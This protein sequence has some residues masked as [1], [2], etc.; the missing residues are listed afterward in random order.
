M[1]GTIRFSVAVDLIGSLPARFFSSRRALILTALLAV[2][3]GRAHAQS[4]DASQAG[5]P[6]TITASWHFQTGDN[7]QWAA[8]AFDDSQWPLLRMDKSWNVQGYGGYSGYAWYRIQ[9]R[10]PPGREPLAL[11][12][13]R[14]GNSAEVY[15]DGQLIGEM[16]RMRPK[17][18]WL[19]RLPRNITSIRLPPALNGKTITL[20]IRAW[21]STRSAP[22]FDAGS[23]AL[24]RL[25]TER[26][27][28]ELQALSVDQSLLTYFPDWTVIVVAVVI[29]LISFGLF[30]LR[31]R[32]REYL[33]AALYLFGETFV[34]AFDVYRQAHQL[35]VNKAA[36]V[37]FTLGGAA[38]ICWFLLVWGFVRA[39]KDRTFWSGVT[40][41]V[42]TALVT[43]LVTTGITSISTIYTIRATIVSFIGLLIFARLSL[44]ALRG[45][46]D[47]QL[48]LAPFL[49]YTVTD[50][51]RFVRLALYYAGVS[52]TSSGLELYRG[53]YFTVTWDRVGFLLAFLAIGA[54]LVRRFAQSAQ[55]EQRL[56]TEMESAREVQA[57]LVPREFPRLAG[58]Q[59]EA[60]YLP[61]AEVGGD[62]Y[63]V[64]EQ[65]DG[66]VLIV[67]G[68]VCGKG[69]KAAMSGVL[70]IGAIR[71]LASQE[72][73]P[74]C[75]LGRLNQEM[76]G[77]QN[78]GFI[79]CT[80]AR[81]SRDGVIT[82]ANAGHPPA[83]RNGEE[84]PMMSGLPLGITRDVE[85]AETCA[86]LVAGDRLT[87]LSDGVLE[88][89][90]E[91]GDFFG[92]ER[93]REISGQPAES[94]ARA[95]RQFGQEDDITVLTLSFRGVGVT[96]P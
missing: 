25:G 24:P 27:T 53:P 75:L 41:A 60:A 30:L 23:A 33:W 92:F 69:L 34:R 84:L 14:V 87:F 96:T 74:G 29:G 19:A 65:S 76:T 42:C 54:V 66:S 90:R 64:V 38:I 20:A 26:A 1:T 9:L 93:T 58:F 28:S 39:K 59:I 86:Q 77:S 11:A 22:A 49:L 52:N 10:L 16:G 55:Q 94:I 82:L 40:L 73:S 81:A 17:P 36:M 80:C 5:G 37:L 79:T 95:A 6:V 43:F 61:A 45:N 12:L 68:D 2:C 48:F 78:G 15:A 35:P 44:E 67:I 13:D 57:Q 51:V 8:P 62:F 72:L 47:A 63:Q 85:Y 91:N 32:A 31:P 88:A 70:A 56:A 4:F 3:L 71:A 83:Y 21:E 89:R 18:E 50:V 7:P 46:R